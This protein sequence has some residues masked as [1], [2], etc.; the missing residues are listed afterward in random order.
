MSSVDSATRAFESAQRARDPARV[1]AH[2]SP[3]FYMHVDGQR[4]GRDAVVQN[5]QRDLAAAHQVEPGF[6]NIEVIVLSAQ[7]AV[8]S[9][10]YHDTVVGAH[11][12]QRRFRGATTL[13][14]ARAYR[15]AAWLIVYAHADHQVDE[16]S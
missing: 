11:N 8:A 5:I 15:G 14:W 12:V 10:R 16:G 6:Q 13:V 2:L 3:D 7:T 9:F 4:L 1:V